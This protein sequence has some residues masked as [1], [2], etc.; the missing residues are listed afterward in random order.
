MKIVIPSSN[1][2]LCGHFGNCEYF[3]FVEADKES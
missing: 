2:K 1:E 3:S